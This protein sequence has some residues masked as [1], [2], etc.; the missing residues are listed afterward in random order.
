MTDRKT[1]QP[2]PVLI[3]RLHVACMPWLKHRN[4]SA[5]NLVPG[6]GAA[7]DHVLEL[8]ENAA[9]SEESRPAGDYEPDKV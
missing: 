2:D 3:T 7:M 6:E 1:I 8:P 5:F 4:R 9:I